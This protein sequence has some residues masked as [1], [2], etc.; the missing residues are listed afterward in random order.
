MRSLV[1][2]MSISLVLV[3][4]LSFIFQGILPLENVKRIEAASK[5]SISEKS[6][7]L[8]LGATK[9]LKITGTTKKVTWTSTDKNVVTV[10]KTGKVTSKNSG[11]ARIIASVN[12][13]K[14]Y[15]DVEV[16]E[17]FFTWDE[18]KYALGDNATIS[19]FLV[20]KKC[21]YKLSVSDK[22]V[23]TA[24]KDTTNPLDVHLTLKKA[25]TATITAS[26]ND[27]KISCKVTVTEKKTTV[28]YLGDRSV[29]YVKLDQ[30]HRLFFSLQDEKQNRISANASVDIRI[31]NDN[32]ET[33]Y[34]SS[35]QVTS[36]NFNNWT[37]A[38]YGEKYVC[39]IDIPDSEIIAG[40][41]KKGTIYFTVYNQGDFAFDES[42][43]S[44][45]NLP[46]ISAASSCSINLPSVPIIVNDYS[47]S[48]K[49]SST[50]NLE[51]IQYEFEESYDG[52]TVNLTIYF[53]GSMIY[54]NSSTTSFG[55]VG[56][57]LYKDGYVVE[58]GT[59]LTPQLNTGDKFKN[60]K[61]SFYGLEPGV[62]TLEILGTK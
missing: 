1:K 26:Y 29:E 10:S 43:I 38:L 52:K 41:S 33:V 8:S 17:G 55:H 42:K 40:A 57:K 15:C 18:V 6:I 20:Y 16:Y 27:T 31:V 49:I 2:K 14:Y 51:S 53:T 48:G 39:S 36:S 35:R 30:C 60:S 23:L 4:M 5:I 34:S 9:Q 45:D 61:E 32:G 28:S 59:H 3:L 11:T 37:W 58:S 12:S 47:Y 7:S 46:Y 54:N 22:S 19:L 13:K 21:D 62:Y 24:E 50:I 44:I 56:Y 25:G